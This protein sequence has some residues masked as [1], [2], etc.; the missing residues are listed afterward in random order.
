MIIWDE[1]PMSDRRCFES[2]DRSLKDVLE[3]NKCHFGG[4]SMLLGGDFRQT[5]PVQPKNTN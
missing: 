2:L 1:A 3:N 4:M 5:L